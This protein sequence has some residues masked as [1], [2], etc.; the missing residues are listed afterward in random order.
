[1]V[2]D[3]AE[4]IPEGHKKDEPKPETVTEL[5]PTLHEAL[6]CFFL[7]CTARRARGHV[8]EHNSMLIHVTRFIDWQDR[9]ATLV[10]NEVNVY[11]RLIEFSD[12]KFLNEL[13]QLW[14]D[15]FVDVTKEVVDNPSVNDPS[16]VKMSW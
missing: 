13:E 16:I 15:R 14:I 11:R 12:K 2:N 9:I 1:I 8:N 10:E 6:K 5:P 7:S 4:Y 3:Y